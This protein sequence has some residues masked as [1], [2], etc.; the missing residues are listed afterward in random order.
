MKCSDTCVV[1][2]SAGERTEDLCRHLAA[3]QV[4]EGNVVVIHE[5]PFRRAVL[6]S[7]EV[8]LDFGLPWTICLD[9]DVVLR[10]G[11]VSEMIALAGAQGPTTFL[12]E[13]Q[14]LDKFTGGP[15]N[16]GAYV[17]RTALF[18]QARQFVPSDEEQTMR[19]GAFVSRKMSDIG[20][21]F[22]TTQLLVGIHEYEQYYRD[23]YAKK[24]FRARKVPYEIPFLLRR[25]LRLGLE[26]QDFWIAAW[27]IV[28]GWQ[29][30]SL[31]MLDAPQLQERAN[32]FLESIGIEEKEPLVVEAYERLSDKMIAEYQP[33]PEYIE[34]QALV[35]QLARAQRQRE[36]QQREQ[37]VPWQHKLCLYAKQQAREVGPLWLLPALSG[38]ALAYVGNRLQNRAKN[39]GK[40]RRKHRQRS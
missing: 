18:D 14:T 23:I 15:Q 22:V 32:R 3:Q 29:V 11:A 31:I 24:L 9:A 1:I 27:G 17:Y 7:F 38:R 21:S 10:Q 6:K 33:P 34:L 39:R 8:G 28:V 5:Y 12:V 40:R 19:A 16:R 2:R 26:D 35:E 37:P 36:Q 30:Q 20:Y 25:C 13:M 4:P